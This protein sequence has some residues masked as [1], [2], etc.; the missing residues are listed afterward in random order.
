MLTPEV[1][2]VPFL[3]FPSP[4]KRPWGEGEERNVGTSITSFSSF[5]CLLFLCQRTQRKDRKKSGWRRRKNSSQD[6]YKD[7][8]ERQR[9][10]SPQG[11]G[12]EKWV[13]DGLHKRLRPSTFPFFFA[14]A[15]S[16]FLTHLR[17]W[18]SSRVNR[19]PPAHGRLTLGKPVP[20]SAR[21]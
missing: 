10:S 11:E 19:L 18:L 15:P 3:S 16:S 20:D 2:E 4:C 14:G 5:S 13:L 7:W 1:I 17:N 8:M 12:K 21:G 9:R 6:S